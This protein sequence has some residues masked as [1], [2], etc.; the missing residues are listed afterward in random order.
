MTTCPIYNKCPFLEYLQALDLNHVSR[1]FQKLYCRSGKNNCDRFKNL[2]LEKRESDIMPNRLKFPNKKKMLRGEELNAIKKKLIQWKKDYYTNNKI[3]DQYHLE[4]II[5]INLIE[6]QY[7][8]GRPQ[9]HLKRLLKRLKKLNE[10]HYDEELSIIKG[11]SD[12]YDKEY[13]EGIKFSHKVFD[14]FYDENLSI[15]DE[16]NKFLSDW[17]LEHISIS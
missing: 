11:N 16:M 8:M 13:L 5:L 4:L 17:V 10:K 2:E 9:N 1:G 15:D 3:M 6:T 7:K 12:K 14:K